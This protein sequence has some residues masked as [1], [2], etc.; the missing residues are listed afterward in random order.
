[1][2][3]GLQDAL[4]A[5]IEAV[6]PDLRRFI[7]PVARG[8]VIAVD[9]E[10]YTVDVRVGGGDDP[11]EDP[12]RILPE[13]PVLS[14]FAQSG[15]G[16]W[17]LPEEGAEV[18]VSFQDGDVTRPIVEGAG[19]FE[20]SHPGTSESWAVG[21][22]A[23][24]GKV[25]QKLEIRPDRN[26][27]ILRAG[28]VRIPVS[29]QAGGR[30]AGDDKQQTVGDRIRQV[31]GNDV[32]QARDQVDQLTGDSILEASR[33]EE[34]I[35][36]DKTETVGGTKEENVYGSHIKTVAGSVTEAVALTK[37]QVIGGSYE[38]L[39]AATPGTC[40]ASGWKVAVAGVA[41]RAE[42]DCLGGTVGIGADVAN[43][44]L[45]VHI[46]STSSGP[47]QLG[48]LAATG[49]PAPC[50]LPLQIILNTLLTVLKTVPL[51]IGNLGAPI[52][53]NPAV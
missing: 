17:A 44:P 18:E 29:D 16:I 10:A 9:A 42:L 15:Y 31:S 51:G 7:R 26:E 52:A 43:P 37:R 25:G 27:I 23:I 34:T 30:T 35:A 12:G 41:S 32:V 28:S 13:V 6:A 3:A 4:R 5:A 8:T 2:S 1:M 47:V 40:G 21:T 39:V 33:R 36:S 38:L 49:Q 19:Y 45:F 53:P 24:K 20:G 11:N 46:G 14:L 50:G 48:G 22:I